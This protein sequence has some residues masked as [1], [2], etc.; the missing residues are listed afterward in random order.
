MLMEKQV[1]LA[2]VQVIKLI[3]PLTRFDRTSLKL[4]SSSGVRVTT[5]KAVWEFPA[6]ISVG[7]AT[8]SDGLPPSATRA[9]DKKAVDAAADEA[10]KQALAVLPER[11]DGWLRL[12]GQT[13]R[14]LGPADCF[15]GPKRFGY[16]FDCQ[17]CMAKGWVVCSN[18]DRGYNRCGSCDGGRVT[19]PQ[20][21]GRGEIDCKGCGARGK[22][23]GNTCPTCNGRKRFVCSLCNGEKKVMCTKCGGTARIVCSTCNGTARVPCPTCEG[24][25]RRHYLSVVSCAVPGTFRVALSDKQDEVNTR[26]R[27][28]KLDSLRGFAR[29]KQLTP[30]RQL[31]TVKRD[32]TVECDITE[33]RLKVADSTLE[34]IGF[35][36]AAQVFN[37]KF[38]V[39]VL[40][41]ADLEMLKK[42]IANTPLRLWGT[43]AQLLEATRLSLASEANM[44]ICDG[45]SIPGNAVTGDYV[46]QVI[47]SLKAAMEKLF[48]V[49][50]GLPLLVAALVPLL[51]FVV[52]YFTGLREKIGPWVFVAP[53]VVSTAAWILL[54][55][56][57]HQL[58]LDAFD[59]TA[60]RRAES[61]LQRHQ[62][63]WKARG[64][65]IGLT[66][67]LLIAAFL[68]LP[69]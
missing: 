45:K 36:P 64:A 21:D 37:F 66:I 35:G 61:L 30:T 43:P 62:L 34:I 65:A 69:A 49:Q 55:Q 54:E 8:H 12:N 13:D 26:L 60:A 42:A 6:S 19:C 16:D 5:G 39:T 56:R 22:K 15:D 3:E 59:R 1:E 25:G 48:A 29:V 7:A 63:L 46:R 44:M 41:E 14:E 53:V 31:N 9:A 33:L 4:G 32:Y 52:S 67:I 18:C 50:A 27:P 40:L 51:F 24:K 20:C 2:L 38:V 68:V 58:L 57:G 11:I 23:D 28:L 10:L 17:N 47:V